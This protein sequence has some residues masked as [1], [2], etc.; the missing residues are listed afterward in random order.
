MIQGFAPLCVNAA[1]MDFERA[2]KD[3]SVF[4]M[5]CGLAG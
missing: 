5:I 1:E 2:K 4:A 3:L